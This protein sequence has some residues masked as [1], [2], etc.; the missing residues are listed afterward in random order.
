MVLALLGG[1]LGAVALGAVAGARRTSTAYGRYLASSNASDVFVNV[2]G[3]LPGMPVT[4]PITLISSLP[5]IV[6]HA[7]YV[8]LNGLPVVHGR[9][10]HSFLLNGLNG[11]LDGEYFS[12]DRMTV[13]AG[14]LPPQGSTTEIVLTPAVARMFGAGVGGTVRYAFR[15]LG[16]Q[17]LPAGRQFIR[18]YRVAAIAEI[19]PALVDESDHPEGSILPPGAT[20]QAL[21]EYFYAWIGLRLARGTAGIP[22][23]QADLAGLARDLQRQENRGTHQ[24]AS[25]LSFSVNRSDIIHHQVQQ[26]IRPEAIALSVFGLAA[27]L[28]MLVLVGQGLAQMTSRSAPEISVIRALGAT[29]A[30]A[31]LAVSLP[32]VV[33][34]LGGVILAVAGAVALSRWHL[35]DPCAASTQ[36]AGSGRM[37]L[38]WGLA[39]SSSP[40]CCS[41]CWPSWR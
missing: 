13:V 38:S 28:A 29:R 31:A 21:A 24:N 23:L 39:H 30:H 17:G 6:S 18:S 10:V 20:R 5:G 8:G 36:A 40:P 3:R 25:G 16:P 7:A 34:V 11:S 32:G 27:A 33:P 1:L 22:A 26:A 19:P 9:L 37:R 4:R 12:Q 2:Y 35:W 14:R 41:G 15:A